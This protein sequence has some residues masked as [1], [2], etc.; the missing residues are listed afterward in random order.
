VGLLV[1]TVHCSAF[2]LSSGRMQSM[3]M[4][5][6]HQLTLPMSPRGGSDTRTHLSLGLI[7][8]RQRGNPSH[9][10]FVRAVR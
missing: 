5:M 1:V 6:D 10:F 3:Q 9:R 2:F 7:P 8:R 4:F